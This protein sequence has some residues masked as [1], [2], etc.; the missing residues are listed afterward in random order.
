VDLLNRFKE[1]I[2]TYQDPTKHPAYV[3]C[4]HVEESAGHMLFILDSRVEIILKPDNEQKILYF[5]S[6]EDNQ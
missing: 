2:I 4:T 6:C 1:N 5:I 3:N